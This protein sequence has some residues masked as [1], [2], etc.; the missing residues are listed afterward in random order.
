MTK[1]EFIHFIAKE[2]EIEEKSIDLK[3]NFRDLKNW[4][5]LNALLFISHL[6]EEKNILISSSDLAQSDTL[7]DLHLLI[8]QKIS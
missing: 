1:E 8:Q 3:S 7:D 6:N 5:S 4:N 2:L